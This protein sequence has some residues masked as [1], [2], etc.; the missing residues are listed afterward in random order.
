MWLLWICMYRWASLATTCGSLPIAPMPSRLR[1]RVEELDLPLDRRVVL[2]H[3]ARAVEGQHLVDGLVLD[4][5]PPH[6]EAEPVGGEEPVLDHDRAVRVV[7][8]LAPRDPT[9]VVL[10]TLGLRVR[11][12]EVLDEFQ[13]AVR[14]PLL[15]QAVAAAGRLEVAE[16]P[17]VG[18]GGGRPPHARLVGV[19]VTGVL[20]VLAVRDAGPVP[21]E[22]DDRDL[23]VEDTETPVLGLDAL[24]V[25]PVVRRHQGGTPAVAAEQVRPGHHGQRHPTGLQADLVD[26]HVDVASLLL[27]L[28]LLTPAE[29]HV[30]FSSWPVPASRS[31]E[32]ARRANSMIAVSKRWVGDGSGGP[33]T[34]ARTVARVSPRASGR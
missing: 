24:V 19:H 29:N 31:R 11:V 33:R 28:L 20:G 1:Q 3:L 8:D 30:R 5:V 17:A 27:L 9:A 10:H 13:R 22:V 4:A 18:A 16:S 15:V 2:P 34:R 7:G 6:D 21:V 14:P 12:V 32:R 23:F 26:E 25:P